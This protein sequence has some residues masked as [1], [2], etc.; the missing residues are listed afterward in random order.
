MIA[1]RNRFVETIRESNRQGLDGWTRFTAHRERVQSLL[2]SLATPAASLCILGPGNLN[3]VRLE[4]LRERFREVHLVDIDVDAVHSALQRRGL[5]GHSGFRAHGPTDLTGI[6]DLLPTSGRRVPRSCA[7]SLLHAL[8]RERCSVQESPFD[9]VASTA[10][11]TQLLQ[12]VVDSALTPGDVVRV[13]LGVRDKH[14]A[15][16]ISLTRRGGTSVLVTDVVS[17]ASAPQ[18]AETAEVELQREMASLVG[19]RNFLTGVNPYRIVAL[20]K[21]DVRLRDHVSDV[22]LLD[23]WLWAVTPDRLHLTCAIV[24]RRS[25]ERGTGRREASRT[26]RPCHPTSAEFASLSWR[27][28]G[29]APSCELCTRHALTTCAWA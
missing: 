23:P 17:T 1:P 3:D 21:Q 25:P 9:V 19:A 15:D 8:E 12:S 26:S 14:L 7:E 4:E 2:S 28:S 22:Q 20:L 5:A 11:L 18:L 13:S 10:A 29:H 6:L 24:A 16:L 27:A